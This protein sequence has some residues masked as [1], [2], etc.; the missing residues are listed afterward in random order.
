M[1]ADSC[2]EMHL[3]GPER[4]RDDNVQPEREEKRPEDHIDTKKPQVIMLSS[5]S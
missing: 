1:D 2:R 5:N 4:L 3:M